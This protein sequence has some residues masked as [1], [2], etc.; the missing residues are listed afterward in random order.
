MKGERQL[1]TPCHTSPHVITIQHVDPPQHSLEPAM[2]LLDTL[3]AALAVVL[4]AT[5]DLF[6]DIEWE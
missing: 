6:I 5:L 1:A 3:I 2:H 4:F